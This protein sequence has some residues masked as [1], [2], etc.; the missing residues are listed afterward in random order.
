MIARK[1]SLKKALMNVVDETSEDIARELPLMQKWAIKCN[2]EIDSLNQQVRGITVLEVHGCTATI[3]YYVNNVV[4]ILLGDRGCDCDKFWNLKTA[5]S[6]FGEHHLNDS[7]F[8]DIRFSIDGFNNGHELSYSIQNDT[9]VFTHDMEGK[10]VTLLTLGYELDADGL[11]LVSENNVDA[12]VKY[13]ELQMTKRDLWKAKK[14]GAPIGQLKQDIL[15][16]T[17]EVNFYVR[18]ARALSAKLTE[19]GQNEL[20]ELINDPITNRRTYNLHNSSN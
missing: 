4:S 15:D 12:I 6:N 3:P 11:P 5:G 19:S 8:S 16:L 7:G 20:A 9:I 18:R 14:K 13:V 1:I 2:N 10:K 17:N